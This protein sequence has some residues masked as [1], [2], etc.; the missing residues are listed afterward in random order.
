MSIRKTFTELA[1]KALTKASEIVS[2][3][4]IREKFS[5]LAGSISSRMSPKQKFTA[6]ASSLI[7]IGALGAM[8]LTNNGQAKAESALNESVH[9]VQLDNPGDTDGA[10]QGT[11][12]ITPGTTL[13]IAD[14]GAALRQE[15]QGKAA[16]YA[17]GNFDPRRAQGNQW[18][19][20][21]TL[22]TTTA[23]LGSWYLLYGNEELGQQSTEM[24][25]QFAGTDMRVYNPEFE[26]TPTIAE[27]NFNRRFAMRD[28]LN[29]NQHFKKLSQEDQ[30]RLDEALGDNAPVNS[31]EA[32]FYN[33]MVERFANADYYVAFEGQLVDHRGRPDGWATF[34]VKPGDDSVFSIQ[35]TEN[36]A[37][38]FTGIGAR[39]SVFPEM[40][41]HIANAPKA[42]SANQ[43]TANTLDRL[44]N[45]L[46]NAN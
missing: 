16:I 38:F 33:E 41:Q 25:V 1:N 5:E 2:Q 21:T 9:A 30:D 18:E 34:F 13:P 8:T 27:H 4:Q 32:A 17:A 40:Q 7:L 42:P 31:K 44:N 23:N 14:M 12:Q 43:L 37:S 3:L 35:T 26:E 36:G 6:I 11:P 39:L 46:K 29:L 28:I 22:M 19:N 20:N 15:G 10:V 24:T 45:T